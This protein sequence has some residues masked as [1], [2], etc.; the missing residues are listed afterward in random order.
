VNG[1]IQRKSVLL[2]GVTDAG[3]TNFLSRLWLALDAGHGIL[4]KAGNP[5][6]LDYL[7]AGADHLLRGE[8]APHT[9]QDVRDATEIPVKKGDGSNEY[10]G[11][12]VVSDW[13]G[14]QI[15]SIFRTRQWSLEWENRISAGCG[16]LLFVR[17]DSPQLIAPL[18]WISCHHLFGGP[19]PAVPHEDHPG[20]KQK[21]PTQ[22]L[23]V[24][25]I[26]FLRAAFTDRVGGSYRPRI[27]I[28][29]TAWDL[30]P[31]DQKAAGPSAWISSNLPLLAQYIESNSDNFDFECFGVSVAS[32][33]LKADEEF[34]KAYL[35]G[36]PRSAGEVVHSLSGKVEASSDM[37]FPVAWALGLL[38]PT[39][40][41]C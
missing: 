12:L 28:V 5:D 9:P 25:W 15:L 10:R 1:S 30:A 24:D 32:G 20:D 41:E 14:E 11:T 3:K 33:D 2:I 37:T 6:D 18:D 22:V 4:A 23:L 13:P 31:N 21:P 40:K 29:V 17:V 38:N 8:F 34:K 27:G 36:D 19:M 16:C 26:Q 7:A 35:K 39:S